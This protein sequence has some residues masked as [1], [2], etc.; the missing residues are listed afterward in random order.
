MAVHILS[1]KPAVTPEIYDAVHAISHEFSG[2]WGLSIV[3]SPSNDELVLKLSAP[4]GFRR[5]VR[6][7]YEQQS[8]EFITRMLRE[9]RDQDIF[10]T[11]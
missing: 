11:V 9:L 10:H 7:Q 8:G 3:N 6:L 5:V 1:T 4:R 2:D